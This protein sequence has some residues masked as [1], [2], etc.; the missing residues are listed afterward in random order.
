MTPCQE[1]QGSQTSK[2]TGKELKPRWSAAGRGSII[3]TGER[4]TGNLGDT[5][6]A[7]EYEHGGDR[8]HRRRAYLPLGK[9][10]DQAEVAVARAIVVEGLMKCATDRE[11]RRNQ[12][13]QGQKAA[14]CRSRQ[15]ASAE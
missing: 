3:E 1:G 8:S 6:K 14:E 11:G 2:R 4:G 5:P 12:Q 10:T 7:A 13:Q 9:G 15:A